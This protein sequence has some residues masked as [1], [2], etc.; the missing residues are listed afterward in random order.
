MLGDTSYKH[1]Q[2]ASAVSNLNEKRE[3]LYKINKNT[4]DGIELNELKKE[5]SKQS[6]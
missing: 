5:S 2:H 4:N 6:R 3:R 1:F